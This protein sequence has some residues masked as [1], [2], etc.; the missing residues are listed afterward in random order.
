MESLADHYINY[1]LWFTFSAP[2]DFLYSL[3]HD[4]LSIFQASNLVSLWPFFLSL[5]TKKKRS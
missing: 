2:E 5:T 1:K 3:A 4:S